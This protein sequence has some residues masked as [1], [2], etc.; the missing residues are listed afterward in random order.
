M[1]TAG[2]KFM[3][4]G[5]FV[6]G[7]KLESFL[8]N[9]PHN[10]PQDP[11]AEVLRQLPD[12]PKFDLT[13]TMLQRRM[14]LPDLGVYGITT[15]SRSKFMLGFGTSKKLFSIRADVLDE[16]AGAFGVRRSDASWYVPDM[17]E[18]EWDELEVD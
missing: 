2:G 3:Y 12:T 4:F 17:T 8:N 16:I 15:E 6:D 10:H 9:Y 7:A 13:V 1:I 11:R 5:F 14:R 18:E